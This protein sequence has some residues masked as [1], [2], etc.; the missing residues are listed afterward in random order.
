MIKYLHENTLLE[1]KTLLLRHNIGKK[2]E[3]P[4]TIGLPI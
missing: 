3:V 4:E 1:I 2:L